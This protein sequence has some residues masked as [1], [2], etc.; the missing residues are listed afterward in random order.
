MEISI[1][2]HPV[3]LIIIGAVLGGIGFIFK[4]IWELTNTQK[5]TTAILDRLEKRQETVD[6][7]MGEIKHGLYSLIGAHN[8]MIRTG[9]IIAQHSSNSM[10]E[11]VGT[12]EQDF[13]VS[14]RI[15]KKRSHEA[16]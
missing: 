10:A 8:A 2:S 4:I 5:T 14:E 12:I 13:R 11:E 16:H 15:T 9:S 3:T 7:D 6:A 1:W